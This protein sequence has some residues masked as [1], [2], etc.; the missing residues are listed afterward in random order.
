METINGLSNEVRRQSMNFGEHLGRAQEGVAQWRL[1]VEETV[2]LLL[3][4]QN[5]FGKH[6][7]AYRGPFQHLRLRS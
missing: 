6:E 4:S 5:R 1:L 2:Q 3:A 7:S